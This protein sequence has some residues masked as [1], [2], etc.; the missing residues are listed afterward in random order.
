M[1]M[2][3]QCNGIAPG[4]HATASIREQEES[5]SSSSNCRD[6][7]QTLQDWPAGARTLEGYL[8]SLRACFVRETA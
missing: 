4:F 5:D 2:R 7:K 3:M 8:P 1:T 6:R